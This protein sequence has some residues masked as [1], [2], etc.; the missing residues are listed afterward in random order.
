MKKSILF[1][2]TLLFASAA[3]VS[4]SSSSDFEEIAQE[5][6]VQT[7]ESQYNQAFIKAFGQPDVNQDWGFDK[8]DVVN[9]QRDDALGNTDDGQVLGQQWKIDFFV[10]CP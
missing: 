9:H 7:V 4:C 10:Y 1:G 8:W 5:N 3:F 6:M 2:M